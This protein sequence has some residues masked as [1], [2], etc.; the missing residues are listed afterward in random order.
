V[1]ILGWQ[2]RRRLTEDRLRHGV[3][4][5]AI[6]AGLLTL[7]AA[8]P[9]GVQFLGNGRVTAP[10]Q[11]ASPYAADLLGLI[12]PTVHQLLGIS[13]TSSWGVNDSENGSYLGLPLV[14]AIGLLAW[15]FRS[16]PV[17]RFASVLA[18]VSWVLSLGERLHAAGHAF[19]IPLP[20][21]VVSTLPV[22]HNLAAV[23][24]SLYVVLAA[25]VVLAVG[26]DRLHANGWLSRHRWPAVVLAVTCVLP[27]IPKS[28]YSYVDADT[29]SYFTTSAVNRVPKDGVAF[30]YPVPRYPGS[31]P[32][33][34]QAQARYRYK[35]L[36][37]YVITR[38]D[39]GGGTFAGRITVW[40]RVVGQATRGM[41]LA[42]EPQVLRRL[43]QELTELHA[44]AILVADV[45]GSDAVNA[46]VEALLQ[47]PPDE[48]VGGVTA[49]YITSGPAAGPFPG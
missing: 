32:M 31:A 18:V 10:V 20:F 26:L 29:P 4:G 11:D 28:P 47:R 27:L 39:S 45:R 36:G 15:R 44:R 9:L 19:D 48:H 8:W 12:A 23:R 5:L 40:E 49:W 2:R 1:V 25:A 43:L 14:M 24:F 16:I 6:A 37:G 33:L 46:L 7:L 42:A 34:W 22:L 13:E 30:T 3:K 38:G 17:V 21:D 35:S 41:S